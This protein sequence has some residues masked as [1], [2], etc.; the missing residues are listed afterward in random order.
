MSV[1][2]RPAPLIKVCDF[3]LK[4]SEK[5]MIYSVEQK[6]KAFEQKILGHLDECCQ[7]FDL[8]EVM[9]I[10]FN[11][12]DRLY[13]WNAAMN[14]VEQGSL[15]VIQ[16]REKFNEDNLRWIIVGFNYEVLSNVKFHP[17]GKVVKV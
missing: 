3:S 4:E 12:K 13:C 9:S 5:A 10:G 11:E 8:E 1:Q 17:P 16:I 15:H 6:V 14:L 7:A 2:V